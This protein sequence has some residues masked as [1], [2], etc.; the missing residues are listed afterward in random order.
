MDANTNAQN[1]T[2][3]R[4]LMFVLFNFPY[5]VLRRIRF[6][7]VS[8]ITVQPKA[9]QSV[10]VRPHHYSQSVCRRRSRSQFPP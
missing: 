3:Y 2:P 6:P 4:W 10:E 1:V 5:A 9:N 8:W 7:F